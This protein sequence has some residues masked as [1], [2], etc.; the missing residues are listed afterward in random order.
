MNLDVV[1]KY[2][3]DIVLNCSKIGQNITF[4]KK[5]IND[6]SITSLSPDSSKYLFENSVLT[7]KNSSKFSH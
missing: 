1:F 3:H 6:L 4:F 7:I 2:K 5:N